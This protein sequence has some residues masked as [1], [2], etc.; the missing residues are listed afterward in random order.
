MGI[1]PK[2]TMGRCILSAFFLN[3]SMILCSRLSLFPYSCTYSCEKNR[4]RLVFN[5]S[6]YLGK[7]FFFQANPQGLQRVER[8]QNQKDCPRQGIHVLSW[9][10]SP[11]S[12]AN[13]VSKSPWPDWSEARNEEMTF[14]VL[15]P[16]EKTDGMFKIRQFKENL[17]TRK[18]LQRGG[19]GLVQCHLE[20]AAAGLSLPQGPKRQGTGGVIRVQK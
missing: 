9:P 12:I 20:V 16:Q 17:C 3:D 4:R 11:F 13:E 6:V 18:Y 5:L 1:K 14:I 2:H 7:L 8:L 15:G 19:W 10:F